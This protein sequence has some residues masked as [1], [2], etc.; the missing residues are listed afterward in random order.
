MASLLDKGRFYY[1]LFEQNE[2]WIDGQGRYHNVT[3]MSVRYK[4]NVIKF[5]ERRASLYGLW[6]SFG[7][8]WILNSPSGP[9]EET[10]AY[11]MLQHE[12]D[13]ACEERAADPEGWIRETPLIKKMLEQVKFG[14]GGEDK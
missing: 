7:E 4:K 11:D 10:V 6:Y 8:S 2:K 3:E 1:A 9:N 13:K 5:V 12:I 14:V